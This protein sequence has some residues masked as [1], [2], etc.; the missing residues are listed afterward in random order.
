MPEEK[1][2]KVVDLDEGQEQPVEVV[3]EEKETEQEDPSPEPPLAATEEPEQEDEM[4]DYSE[5]VQ[6]RIKKLTHKMREAERREKAATDYAQAMKIQVDQLSTRVGQTDNSYLG[7]YENRLIHE[8]NSLKVQLKEAIESGDVDKQMELNKK[9]ATHAIDAEKFRQAKEFNKQQSEGGKT[10]QTAQTAQPAQPTQPAQ[11]SEPSPKAVKWAEKNDWFGEDEPMTLTA[12]SIHNALVA[13]GYD[14]ENQS[15]DYYSEL[16]TR[17]RKEFPHKFNG[18]A[19]KSKRPNAVSAPNR[20]KSGSRGKNSV[21]LSKSQVAI[22]KKLGV[23]L[24]DYAKQ[25]ARLQQQT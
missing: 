16:D 9:M 6:K 17:I 2:E 14:P 18:E 4:A 1:E 21:T 8:E 15:E 10:A 3:V 23:S 25:V 5:S 13:E 22:A 20:G 19:T 7:E 24:E 12:F 11:Q